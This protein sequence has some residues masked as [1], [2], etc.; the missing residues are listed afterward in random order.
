MEKMNEE[1]YD[2][3]YDTTKELLMSVK[4]EGMDNLIKYLFEESDFTTAPASTEVKRHFAFN[5]GLMLHSL[6]CYYVLEKLCD[7]FSIEIKKES[8]ILVGLCHDLVKVDFYDENI[9]KTTKKQS[10]IKPFKVKE[11]QYYFGH[12]VESLMK[13]TKHIKISREEQIMIQYHMGFWNKDFTSNINN[14]I[15]KFPNSLLFIFTDWGSTRFIEHE[16]EKIKK[17]INFKSEYDKKLEELQNSPIDENFKI[18]EIKV[19]EDENE[20]MPKPNN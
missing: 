14:I 19:L 15:D 16:M 13:I 8:K 17:L 7:V 6:C 11:E 20:N 18:K 2:Y 1:M 12:E 3:V 4:R 10:E 5:G 9:L